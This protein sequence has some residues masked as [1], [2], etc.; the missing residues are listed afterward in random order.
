MSKKKHPAH[1]A[2]PPESFGLPRTGVESHAH[3]NG[4]RFTADLDEVVARASRAGLAYIMQVFLSA[5][6][7]Q[8]D[9]PRFAKYPQ[10]YCLLGLHPTD[11][12]DFAD[13][14]AELARI[15]AAIE[16]DRAGAARIRALGEIGLDYYWKE[17]PPKAQR[18]VFI[19]QLALA[20]ELALPVVIHCRDAV[21]DTLEILDAQGFAGYPLL[22]H[23]F[24]GDWDLAQ[25][26]LERGWHIS[27]PGPVTFPGNEA[28]REAVARIP[29]ERLLMETDCPYLAPVP[30]RGRRNE[31]A[32]L[33]F[34]IQAMARARGVTPAELWTSCGR[35]AVEFFG[36]PPLGGS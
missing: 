26:I 12:H 36:L 21:D 27:I 8:N 4:S 5:E 15:R 31:P 25:G 30:H 3:L 2:P 34:T 24:G 29:A 11:V 22:W 14:D 20:R 32:F 13:V 1:D 33:A 10:I 19:K 35:A 16:A 23:C 7:W 28:L 18:P 9:Y 6:S 17:V